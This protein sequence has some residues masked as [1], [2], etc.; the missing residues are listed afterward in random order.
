MLRFIDFKKE[1]CDMCADKGYI[2]TGKALDYICPQCNGSSEIHA[3]VDIAIK[4]NNLI[5][6]WVERVVITIKGQVRGGKNNMGITRTGRHYPKPKFKE[7]RDDAVSQVLTHK[8]NMITEPCTAEISYFAGDCRRRDVPAIL[9]ALFHV[10]ERAGVVKD[11][12]LI[13][14]VYFEKHYDKE[15]PKAIIKL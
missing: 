14:N 6:K 3:T 9:D 15:D 12:C 2:V 7:W 11:D 8:I 5:E 4:D 10:L 13:E 1:K